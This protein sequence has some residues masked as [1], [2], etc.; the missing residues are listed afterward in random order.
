MARWHK[1]IP[2]LAVFALVFALSFVEIADIDVWWHMKCGELFLRDGHV[3]R[4]EI[5]SYTAAG[6]PWVDGYLPA[7]V[8]LYL[9]WWAGN[10]TGVCLLGAAMIMAAY[11]LALFMS[12]RSGAGYG[13]AL[14]A[15][16][17]AVLLARSVMLPRPALLSPI[18]ALVT[19]QLLEEHRLKGGRRAWWIIP[20]TALWA[21]CHPAFILGPVLTGI[22]LTGTLL[23][24]SRWK[25]LALLL[26]GQLI[27]TLVNPYGYEIYYSTLSLFSTPELIKEIS[28]WKPLYGLP[29]LAAGTMAFFIILVAIWVAILIWR[30]FRVRLTHVLLFLFFAVST[31]SARRNLIMFGPLSLVIIAWT[32]SSAP[33]GANGFA[34][35]RLKRF[36]DVAAKAGAAL[37]SLVALVLS[38]FAATDRL[39]FYT[40]ETQAFGAGVLSAVF[41]VKAVELLKREPVKGNIF[42]AYGLGGYLIFNLYPKY[43]V[44]ID[45]RAYP[46]PH[47][48]VKLENQFFYTSD[49]INTLRFRYDIRAVL[50]PTYPQ[51]MWPAIN[52]FI[53]SPAWAV[54]SAEESAVLFL[55]RG[56]GNDDIINRF[57]MNLLK[58]PPLFR[59]PPPGRSYHLWNRAEYAYG[60]IR[61]EKYYEKIAL[62]DLAARALKPALNYRPLEP[63]IEALYGQL[64]IK[65]GNVEE[66]IEAV[67]RALA[68]HPDNLAALTGLGNYYLLRGD[69]DQAEPIFNRVLDKRPGEAG[70]WY[71]LGQVSMSRRDYPTAALRFNKAA[72][73]KP[74]E[75]LFWERLGESLENLDRSG[76]KEAYLRALDAAQKAGASPEEISRIR[77]LIEKIPR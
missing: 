33:E 63:D 24:A 44:F 36:K 56:A 73:L 17:P 40:H 28:E 35:R 6:K 48:L 72:T 20:V 60:P 29:K 38:W 66:G 41:P 74:D 11:G 53:H 18:F 14:V 9:A 57:E 51:L 34:P 76:A 49:V 3:P 4:T 42:H 31:V 75:S 27:A 5:F 16:I 77:G 37:I 54:V 69:Y 30:R 43:R 62:H 23:A 19:L 61:W 55:A 2:L 7:Q 46:Y 13:A 45:S 58:D 26:C 39:D 71:M 50:L 8:L 10:A 65:A 70:L 67:R 59:T 68:G 21:N 64:Q 15:A 32:M 12:R 25:Q 52:A 22:Y 1:I 47:E